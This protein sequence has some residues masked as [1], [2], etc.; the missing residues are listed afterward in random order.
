MHRRLRII[1]CRLHGQSN[2]PTC[3]TI[4]GENHKEVNKVAVSCEV[5][6]PVKFRKSNNFDEIL[7]WPRLKETATMTSGRARSNTFNM[8]PK[9]TC[10]A[11]STNFSQCAQLEISGL[12][13]AATPLMAAADASSQLIFI[14]VCRLEL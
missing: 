6:T 7:T 2:S 13:P 9:T 3:A 10:F 14:S 8:L 4:Q 1:T 12:R 5:Q 11:P